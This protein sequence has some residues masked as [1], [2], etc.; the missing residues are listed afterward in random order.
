MNNR[1]RLFAV[2]LLTVIL[3]SLSQPFQLQAANLVLVAGGGENT[4]D[5]I[6]A[7]EAK[8]SAPFGVDFDRAGNMYLVEMTGYR[9]RKVDPR[10]II[11]TVAGTGVKGDAGDGGPAL[12]AQCNGMHNLAVAP[13]EDIFLA[14]TWNNRVRKIDAR[15]KVISTA[16]GTGERGFSGD[17]G[18]AAQAKFGNIYCA[19]LDPKGENL[20]L[21][22][23]DN[24]RVRAVNLRTGIVRTVAGNGDKGA[25]KDGVAAIEAP[26]VD[27]RA[28]AADAKGNIYVLERSGNALRAVDR[29]GKIHSVVGTGQK[30]ASGNGGDARLAT[31]NGPKHLCIDLDGNV[32]IADTENH[33]IRKYLPREGKIVRVAGNG[34]KG[35]NGLNGPPEEAE[36]NQPHG[37]YMHRDGT[38]YIAD[39]SND[40]VLKIER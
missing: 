14:D 40:R 1:S 13:N 15:T 17:G 30:G 28:V 12:L 38:L 31:L 36:L 37:V 5:G 18:P 16:V 27:P 19:S 6:N 32:I 8:L 4:A 20:Y 34:K 33:A 22:D 26:L 35:V 11:T 9:V 2:L 7:T 25:P 21:A 10:G 23:L 24:R 3:S 29:D 39:S